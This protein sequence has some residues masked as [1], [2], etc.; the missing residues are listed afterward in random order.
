MRQISRRLSPSA[1]D[2][3]IPDSVKG[4]LGEMLADPEAAD[5]DADAAEMLALMMNAECALP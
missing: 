5:V 3:Q 2:V 4:R 1:D